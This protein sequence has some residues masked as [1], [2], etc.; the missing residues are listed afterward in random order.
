MKNL[1][2]TV[3]VRALNQFIL[4]KN[5]NSYEY[6]YP[7]EEIEIDYNKAFYLYDKNLVD[8]LN[9]LYNDDIIQT[10]G[11]KLFLNLLKKKE[12]ALWH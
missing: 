10:E 9:P 8:I 7:N 2:K 12:G 5:E 11:Y 3:T 6:V 1:D 4:S